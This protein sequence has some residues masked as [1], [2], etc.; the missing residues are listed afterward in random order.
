MPYQPGLGTLDL[1]LAAQY[2]YQRWTA[3]LA[4]QHV[5]SQ[6]NENLFYHEP[7]DDDPD[8][9]KY[10]ESAYLERANDAVARVQYVV[11]IGRF[12]LQPGLLAIYHLGLDSR[13]ELESTPSP[14]DAEAFVRR[15][16][17]GSEGLTLNITA[18]LRCTLSSRWAVEASYGSP[19]ITRAARPD[20]LTRS[21]V[22]NAGL[23]YAF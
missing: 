8:A 19:L 1:L 22:L 23:R 15:D 18:D 5:L 3:V 6:E 17:E 10:F 13:L 21:L 9:T 2:R 20:G 7:W 14:W 12:S 16:I 4:Y 11:P